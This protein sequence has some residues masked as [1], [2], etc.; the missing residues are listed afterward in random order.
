MVAENF[1]IGQKMWSKISSLA[2][3]IAGLSLAASPQVAA[4]SSSAPVHLDVATQALT[5][6][7]PLF[8]AQEKR[9]FAEE[10][11]DVAFQF[12]GGGTVNLQALAIKQADI[13]TG[14]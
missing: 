6:Q 11:L 10:H 5:T 1:I 13:A 9:Y 2:T 12:I 4:Q 3:A 7:A 14:S 8:I